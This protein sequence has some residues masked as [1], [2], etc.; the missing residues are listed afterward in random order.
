MFRSSAVTGFGAA[1]F[2]AGGGGGGGGGG[3][4]IGLGASTGCAGAA[5]CAA[6]AG[7]FFLHPTEPVTRGARA[8]SPTKSTNGLG[9]F[10]VHLQKMG[11]DPST[12][13]RCP[14][15]GCGGDDVNPPC[16]PRVVPVN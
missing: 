16:E 11:P 9:T 5:G 4:T 12:D 2:G 1:G 3:S 10:K 6:S 13:R 7:G 15:E 14:H 8:R